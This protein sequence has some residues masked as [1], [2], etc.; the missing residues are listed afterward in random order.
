MRP[1]PFWMSRAQFEYWKHTH[2]TVDVV[3]GRGSRVLGRG[4]R[5]RA[6][7]DPQPVHH[8]G[9]DASSSPAAVLAHRRGSLIP[10]HRVQSLFGSLRRPAHCG[11]GDRETAETWRQ[12]GWLW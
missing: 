3:P 12:T 6:L 7:P 9:A 1:V 8:L 5:R 11:R 4:A 10:A 2:L